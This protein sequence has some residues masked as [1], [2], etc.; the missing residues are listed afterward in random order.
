MI[1]SLAEWSEQDYLLLAIPHKKTDWLPY[2]DEILYSY[3]ELTKIVSKYQKV[4]LIAPDDNDFKPFKDIKNTEFFICETNDTWIRDY[5][6]IDILRDGKLCSL[7]F[8]F[9]AWGNKFSS[10][11]DNMVNKKLFKNKFKTR[12]DDVNLI[13]EGG[14]IDFNGEGIMLSTKKCLLNANRN[15]LEMSILDT[16]LKELFGLKKIVWLE[17]GFIKGD[18][19][20][21]H[22]DTLAR[23]ID[24]KTVAVATCDDVQDE[25]FGELLAMKTELLNEGFEIL[26]LPIPSAKFYEGK[27]LGATYANFI[28]INNAIIVPTYKDKND[29]L[30][31]KRFEN[32]FKDKDVI[33]L[34]AT[35]FIRQ[36]GSLHCSCQNRFKGLR[37]L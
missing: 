34:D 36:N 37:W 12:L 19:T 6:A 20:D 2:L 25:H 13:L 3:I 28:F 18:D 29:D 5:G 7:N 8:T 26:E 23:F 27:R 35:V 1:K 16:K 14:S 4:L 24:E 30:I 33:G 21:S 22:I 31:L 32:F 9:N 17:H 11:L 10:E 15:K